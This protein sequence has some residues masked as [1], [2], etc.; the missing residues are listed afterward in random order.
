MSAKVLRHHLPLFSGTDAPLPAELAEARKPGVPSRNIKPLFEAKPV[1]ATKAEP[2]PLTAKA[3]APVQPK[4]EPAPDPAAILAAAVKAARAEALAEAQKAF[5][6]ERARDAE[7]FEAHLQLVRQQW[8]LET[9]TTMAE[10]LK[11]AMA[12]MEERIA[13]AV[14][15]ILMPFIQDGVRAQAL[16]RLTA[17]VS[18]LLS[19]PGVP[20]IRVSGPQDMLDALKARCGELGMEYEVKDEVDVR[21]TADDTIIETQLRAWSAHLTEALA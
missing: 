8:I 17:E 16:E 15:R 7:A 9:G 6:A 19:T 11:G 10:G 5:E 12:E 2:V 4:K 18:R 21:V 13:T 14:G 20:M 3:A 1:A